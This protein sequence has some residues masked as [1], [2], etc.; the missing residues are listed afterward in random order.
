MKMRDIVIGGEYAVGHPEYPKKAVAVE[1]GNLTRRVYSGARWDFQ[2]H[3]YTGPS[4]RV[5]YSADGRS[6]TTA[7]DHE[8]VVALTQVLRP[9]EEQEVLNEKKK[10]RRNADAEARGRARMLRNQLQN[11]LMGGDEPM[12]S[13]PVELRLSQDVA[14]D[15]LLKLEE[16]VPL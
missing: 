11:E 2:G 10:A 8:E 4:C 9:W 7:N 12:E 1:V 15:L 14:R 5:R 3:L 6:P 16:G 13:F